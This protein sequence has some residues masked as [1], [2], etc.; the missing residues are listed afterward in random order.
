M[1]FIHSLNT[2]KKLYSETWLYLGVESMSGVSDTKCE[3]GNNRK[4]SWMVW[5]AVCR[6]VGW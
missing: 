3:G 2:V 1:C 5:V 4:P 6:V